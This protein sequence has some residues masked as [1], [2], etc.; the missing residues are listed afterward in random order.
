MQELITKWRI[1][2]VEWNKDPKNH[3]LID[4]TGEG[5][6]TEDIVYKPELYDFMEYISR[7]EKLIKEE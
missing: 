3:K 7:D 2:M 4:L 6:Y 1:F 5:K